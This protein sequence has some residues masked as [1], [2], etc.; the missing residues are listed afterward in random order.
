MFDRDYFMR[1]INQMSVAFG[2]LMGL[3]QQGKHEEALLLIDEFMSKELRMRARLALGLSDADLIQMFG[4]GGRSD[5]EAIGAIGAFLQEEGDVLADMGRHA[6]SLP[7]LEKALR[8]IG[9]V[10]RTHGPVEGL[11]L[12]RRMER[13]AAGPALA[14]GSAQTLRAAWEWQEF[15]GRYA[16][17]ENSLYEL[18]GAGEAEPVEGLAFYQRMHALTDHELGRG[19]LSQEELREGVRQWN[20]LTKET[21]S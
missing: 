18:F 8:L 11:D 20:N 13:L 21:A 10:L 7:R 3:K 1:M 9:Y 14:E 4:G 2:A 5:A 16:D 15:A 19:G 12:E 6:D 17:A